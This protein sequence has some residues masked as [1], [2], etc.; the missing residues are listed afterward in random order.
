MRKAFFTLD[1][2]MALGV[3]AI[4]MVVLAAAMS[5][6]QRAV[7]GLADSRRATREAESTLCQIQ[8][9][10]SVPT[11]PA[12]EKVQMRPLDGAAPPG[13]RWVQ[14]E[15]IAAGRHATLSGLVPAKAAIPVMP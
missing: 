9:G 14:I 3:L 4:L 8:A 12:D 5:R 2:L 13:Q 15:V 10:L 11:A 7:A 6:Q 1:V